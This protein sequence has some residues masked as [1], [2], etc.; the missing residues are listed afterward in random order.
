MGYLLAHWSA[1]PFLAAAVALAAWHETGLARL[2]R[3]SR[4]EAR[5][6]RLRSLWFYSGLVVLLLAVQSPIDYWTYRYFFM[7]MIQHVLLMF[8][9]PPLVVAGAPWG[10]LLAALPRHRRGGTA[11]G[12]LRA[13]GGWMLAPWP[14]VVLFNITMVVWHL[15]G[16][17]DVGQANQYVHLWLMDSSFF[18][19]GV[20]F[21]LQVIPS[22]PLSHQ[23]TPADQA[24]ALFATDVVMWILAMALGIF[25]QTSWYPVY[26]RVPGVALPPFAGQQIGA[27]ILWICGDF[28][29]IPAMV[30]VI[31]RLVNREGGI[32]AAVGRLLDRGTARHW[33]AGRAG[34]RRAGDHV[35]DASRE[36]GY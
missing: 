16:P 5:Q 10:P 8:A 11:R 19:A 34:G 3:R 24:L 33:T 27:G 4:R 18:A 36:Q 23:M 32:D 31:R 2:A 25:T 28:W 13:A 14:A 1:G 21:W 9:A 22:P 15:P 12:V 17:L 7:H 6:R 26:A 35:V 30:V 20:L 29:A